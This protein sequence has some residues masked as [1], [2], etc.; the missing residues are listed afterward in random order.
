MDI[1]RRSHQMN[2]ADCIAFTTTIALMAS[3]IW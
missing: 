1:R 2:I 3:F